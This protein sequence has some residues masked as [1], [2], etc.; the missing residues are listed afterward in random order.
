MFPRQHLHADESQQA[1]HEG[2]HIGLRGNAR[3]R[4]VSRQVGNPTHPC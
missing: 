3:L 1:L 4:T 2:G